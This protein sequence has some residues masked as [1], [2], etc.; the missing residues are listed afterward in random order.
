MRWQSLAIASLFGA[1]CTTSAHGQ[2][3]QW[4][5]PNR[6]FTVETKELADRWPHD[7]P[8]KLWH[9]TLGEGYSAIVVEHSALYTTYRCGDEEVV[10]SLDASTG[11]TLWEHAYNAK[12]IPEPYVDTQHGTGPNATPLLIDDHIYTMGFTAKL[13]CLNKTTGEIVWFHVTGH[14]KTG[15]V[16]SNQNRPVVLVI[17]YL[18]GPMVFKPFPSPLS[19][20][21][22]D[23]GRPCL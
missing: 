19:S 23:P 7:G 14:L 11:K 4:G 16:G 22:A 12:V 13:H 18:R 20:V 8:K 10:I 5:G 6:N 21:W 2:W 1:V 3:P 15:R 17:L 9:R